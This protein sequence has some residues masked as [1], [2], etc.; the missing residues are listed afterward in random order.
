[1]RMRMLATLSLSAL[2]AV[3]ASGPA[4][5][6]SY[7]CHGGIAAAGRMANGLNFDPP[8]LYDTERVARSRA[9][10]V[11]RQKVAARCPGR[12]TFWWRAH[13]KRVDCEGYAGGVACEV[14]AVPARKLLYFGAAD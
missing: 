2:L 6:H 11:W 14:R 3:A 1:M 10:A 9:I 8:R 5:A 13:D 7:S 12:S 4:P